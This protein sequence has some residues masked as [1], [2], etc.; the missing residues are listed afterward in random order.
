M[1]SRTHTGPS[2]PQSLL[3]EL[4]GESSSAH[5]HGKRKGGRQL[6]RKE[7]RK[8]ERESRKQRKADHFS[9]AHT[10]KPQ[11]NGKRRADTD[12]AESPQ[13]KKPKVEVAQ[14][15]TARPTPS[16]APQKDARKEMNGADKTKKAK[17][18][19][20]LEKLA[21]RSEVPRGTKAKAKVLPAPILRDSR[22]EEDDAYIAYLEKKLG[23]TKG[24]KRTT[25]YGKGE[26]EDGLDDLL[27]DLDT[28]DATDDID[29]EASEGDDDEG[30]EDEDEDMGDE[31]E[32]LQEVDKAEDEEWHGFGGADDDEEDGS[33]PYEE[34]TSDAVVPAAPSGSKYVPPHLRKRA[35]AESGQPS[36]AQ[37]KLTKQLKGLLNRM[38]EQNMASIVEGVE[39]IYRNNRRHDVT[40]TLTKLIVDGISSHSMH[41]DQYVVLHAAFVSALHKLVGIEFAAFFVQHVVA[42]YDKHYA[43]LDDPSNVKALSTEDEPIGKECSNLVVLLSELYN[44]QVISSV[45]MYDVIRA[46]L[47]GDLTEFKVELLLKVAR[48]S[49][50]QLRQD[51]PTALKSIIQVVHT[52]LPPDASALSSRTRFMIETLSNLKN[53]KVKKA[54]GQSAG[55][56]AVDRMKKFLSGLSKKRQVMSHEPLRVSLKD[57]RSADSKGKWWLVGAAWGGDPLV[58][59]QQQE[60]QF[61]TTNTSAPPDTVSENTLLKLAKK[62]GMNT[63][64]RRSIFVVLMSSDDYVDACE[65][66]SQLKLTEVQQREI[67]RVILHCCGNLTPFAQQEKQ[68][69]PYYAFVI[70]QLCR[71]SHSHKITLQFC[72]WDFL[73]DM[74]ETTVGGAEILKNLSEDDRAGFNVKS[75]S[76]SRMRN[77]A[78]AYGWWLAKDC[79]TLAVLKP[80]DFTV[81][82]PQSQTFLRELFVHTLANT[83]L[84]TPL[85]AEGRTEDLPTTRNRGPLE[86]VFL[87]GSKI[88]AVAL[89]LVYFLQTAFKGEEGFLRWASQVALDTLRT[90][91]ELVPAF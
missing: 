68:Y 45:L 75:I 13:R 57:L 31:E 51:D 15:A 28:F 43:D 72:L 78:R 25:K 38:S 56:E 59:R 50:Q 53:N 86:E 26:E 58:D 55:N 77:V 60:A 91:M 4:N 11:T 24:G 70:Q 23:W 81:L 63:D 1:S 65:R 85:L 10:A 47:A 16:A 41:L 88:Q 32:S 17:P 39:E 8:L 2:L 22:D 79:C 34:V 7:A 62:Q 36:E 6:P 64:I 40:E 87:R 46:L 76:P 84:A 29:G 52:K 18:K 83:Q 9:A 12:H 44:F 33:K 19:T 30:S 14:P 20:A 3:E 42:E 74:G 48:N 82:K 21:E 54:A 5:K 71:L 67:I 49:G 37:L 66:L 73:R 80:V 89:G 27:K 61:Q 90:G 35:E 69:N